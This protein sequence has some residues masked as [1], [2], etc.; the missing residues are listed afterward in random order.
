MLSETMRALRRFAGDVAFDDAAGNTL[1]DGRLADAGL[2]D[3]HRIVLLAA[4][5][6]GQHAADL[7]IAPGGRIELA[8]ACLGGQV[9]AELVQRGRLALLLGSALVR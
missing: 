3:Q 5:Q 2:A 1:D 7:P 8:L 4:A 6:H 9:A